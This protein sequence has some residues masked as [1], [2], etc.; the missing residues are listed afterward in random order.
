[1][2]ESDTFTYFIEQEP[3][4][5]EIV[6]AYTTN[7]FKVVLELLDRQSVCDTVAYFLLKT[8]YPDSRATDLILYLLPTFRH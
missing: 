6:D 8:H 1:M 4:I 5:R 3:Y 2:V 7:N